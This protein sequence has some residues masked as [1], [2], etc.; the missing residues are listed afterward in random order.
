[1]IP[2]FV[3]TVSERDDMTVS[4]STQVTLQSE[5][6]SEDIL[7]LSFSDLK[8]TLRGFPF[9]KGVPNLG[10]AFLTSD[11]D[12]DNSVDFDIMV[13]YLEV[14]K[15][16]VED[17]TIECYKLELQMSASGLMRIVTS[18]MPKT[19]FWYSVEAPHYLVAYEGSNGPPGSPTSYIE[20]IDYSGWHE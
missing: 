7:V 1:M 14:D 3:Y 17:R 2:F 6:Q 12:Y 18:F 11:D 20:I 10:I 13:R 15:V 19:Y 9:G 4:S 8:Y 5:I 16:S